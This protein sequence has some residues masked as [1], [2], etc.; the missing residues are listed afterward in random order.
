MIDGVQI[1]ALRRIDDARGA[2]IPMLRADAPHF[3][4]FGELYFSLIA[5][6]AIKAWKLH[7]RM[8]LNLCVP[9]GEVTFVLM[10]GRNDSPTHGEIMIHRAIDT[11]PTLLV[12][13]P[14]VWSGF[15]NRT[16]DAAIVANCA[17]ILHDPAEANGLP[18]D[19]PPFP[20]DWARLSEGAADV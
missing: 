18:A 4:D 2:V 6:G 20:F 14:G 8:T 10:D 17:D 1:I 7:T 12:V 16:S 5:P 13:P 11:T 15:T 3:R 9:A 19:E